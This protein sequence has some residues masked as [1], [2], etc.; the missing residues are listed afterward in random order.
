MR[1]RCADG[2]MPGYLCMAISPNA[3]W[4]EVD[5]RLIR[6]MG[7]VHAVICPDCGGTGIAH[8]CSGET[9]QNDPPEKGER[10][11]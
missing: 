11:R 7:D 9:S 1:C 4:V 8:C 6:L 5:G 10:R 2:P 3:Q